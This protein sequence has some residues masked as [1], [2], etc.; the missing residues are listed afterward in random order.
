MRRPTSD[1][2]FSEAAD[3]W[4]GGTSQSERD[5]YLAVLRSH[6]GTPSE[7]ARKALLA[8]DIGAS[9]EVLEE[10]AG[11]V[12]RSPVLKVDATGSGTMQTHDG[13]VR[14]FKRITHFKGSS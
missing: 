2:G 14:H 4:L 5:R 3:Q 1:G 12:S 13:K 9:T 10:L 11:V 6:A 7:L 8:A